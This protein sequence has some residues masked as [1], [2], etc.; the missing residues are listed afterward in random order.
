[1]PGGGGEVEV[2]VARVANLGGCCCADPCAW[3]SALALA[4]DWDRNGTYEDGPY[5]MPW[6]AALAAYTY[7]IGVANLYPCASGDTQTTGTI[8]TFL[9]LKPYTDGTGRF[10]WQKACYYHC[11]YVYELGGYYYCGS[12]SP[13]CGYSTAGWVATGS[14]TALDL[15]PAYASSGISDGFKWYNRTFTEAVNCPGPV[16]IDGVGNTPES[17]F[18]PL[19][20]TRP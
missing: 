9:A 18:Y 10:F 15:T 17:A 12:T 8:F 5:S 6:N 2:G 4:F 19:R 14:N 3:P 1:M 11:T 20:I 13:V 16:L 7:A